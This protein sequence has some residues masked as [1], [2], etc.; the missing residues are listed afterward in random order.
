[1]F[2]VLTRITTS[3]SVRMCIEK[4]K[5]YLIFGPGYMG[6][7]ARLRSLFTGASILFNL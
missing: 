2:D 7:E 4:K 6:E 1:M 5:C 3:K